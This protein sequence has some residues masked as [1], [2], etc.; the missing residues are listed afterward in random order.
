MIKNW[1]FIFLNATHQRVRIVLLILASEKKKIQFFV[2]VK[3]M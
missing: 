2:R 3:V 1:A